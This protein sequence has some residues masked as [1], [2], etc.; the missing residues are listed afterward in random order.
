MNQAARN[1]QRIRH[2]TWRLG[3]NDSASVLARSVDMH[4]YREARPQQGEERDDRDG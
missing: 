2:V 1:L 4:G 3:R